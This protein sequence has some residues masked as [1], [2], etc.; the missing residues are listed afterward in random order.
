[1][2]AFESNGHWTQ[3][4]LF[5]TPSAEVNDSFGSFANSPLAATEAPIVR[6]RVST[7]RHDSL[8]GPMRSCLC[9]MIL[10][11]SLVWVHARARA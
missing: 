8:R 2:W 9:D 5:A 1:M 4:L 7:R 10:G 6:S 11:R 3:A